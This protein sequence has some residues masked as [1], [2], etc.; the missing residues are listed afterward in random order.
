MLTLP[1]VATSGERL[2]TVVY[3]P[4]LIRELEAE[5]YGVNVSVFATHLFTSPI[6]EI[7]PSIEIYMRWCWKSHRLQEWRSYMV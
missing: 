2:S 7:T 6:T 3:H 1:P 5:Q 4:A